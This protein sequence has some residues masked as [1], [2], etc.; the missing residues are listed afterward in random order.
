MKK[1]PWFHNSQ[2]IS[3]ILLV[4]LTV[5]IF[6][7]ITLRYLLLPTGDFRVHLVFA[8]ELYMKSYIT[9]APHALY[10]QLVNITYAAVPFYMLRIF[11][12]N[13]DTWLTNYT[14]I[15]SA[16]IVT[17]AC[18]VILGLV[19]Y[20]KVPLKNPYAK[21]G[22]ALALMVVTP[23]TLFT[24]PLHRLYLG[25]IGI[26]IYHNPTIRLLQPLSLLLFWVVLL[27]LQGPIK[28][29][30]WLG[31]IALVLLNGMAKPNFLMD[32]IPGLG[33]WLIIKLCFKQKINWLYLGLAV[34]LP[35]VVVLGYQYI[36]LGFQGGNGVQFA[37]L[38]EMLRY[39]P[40]RKALLFWLF[41]SVAF[42]AAVFFAYIKK[43]LKEQG[44]ILAS[45]F[46]FFGLIYTYLFTESGTRQ[47]NLN[48]GWSAEVALFIL[49]VECTFFFIKQF[50]L[51]AAKEKKHTHW[52]RNILLT[53]IFAL[54]LVSG[55]LY[56]I[57][58]LVQPKMWWG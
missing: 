25:Y 27:N 28:K 5:A 37:P 56:Y 12:G 20:S 43:F 21:A 31:T 51:I 44:L 14:Y 33:V 1:T 42:P 22:L 32:L 23:I 4:V 9:E 49:F 48:L 2:K 26:N 13:M 15:I 24:I 3:L 57:V 52:I 39:A 38:V 16:L 7:S 58:E 35:C 55:I 41:M 6:G 8:Q 18:Y 50:P 29:G 54:H 46:L 10:E 45:L 11:G 53:S 34:F 40:A 19:I 47:F 17:V 36:L 30:A